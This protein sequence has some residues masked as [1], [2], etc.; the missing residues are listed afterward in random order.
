MS[1][2]AP[3]RVEVDRDE[4]VGIAVELEALADFS[5]RVYGGNSLDSFLWVKLIGI[6]RRLCLTHVDERTYDNDE[7][8][9]E[10]G[11]PRLAELIEE[12]TARI[13][14]GQ[15]GLADG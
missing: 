6:S 8:M 1:A 12:F 10:A 7:T 9:F 2:V 11:R 14:P 5:A 15:G 3:V 4:L 13:G